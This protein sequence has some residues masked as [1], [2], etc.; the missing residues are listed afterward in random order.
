VTVELR[1]EVFNL[2]NHPTFTSPSASLGSVNAAGVLSKSNTFGVSTSML[3]QGL[4]SAGANSG[5]SPLYQMGGPR[6]VQLS[7]KVSF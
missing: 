4:G 5:F 3:N 7:L 1:G 2:L 6:S